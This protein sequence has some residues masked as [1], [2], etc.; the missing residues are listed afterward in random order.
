MTGLV[1][2]VTAYS[3][4]ITYK[5]MNVIPT[6]P[7][8]LQF[9]AY[10][11][12]NCNF[13]LYVSDDSIQCPDSSVYNATYTGK[14]ATLNLFYNGTKQYKFGVQMQDE[15][16][17]YTWM[18]FLINV[19]CPSWCN[20]KGALCSSDTGCTCNNQWYGPE[21]GCQVTGECDPFRTPYQACGFSSGLGLGNQTCDYVD[22]TQT[23][24]STCKLVMC[25]PDY[26]PDFKNNECI[27]NGTTTT[28]GSHGKKDFLNLSKEEFI[29]VVVGIVVGVVI[30]AGGVTFYLQKRARGK[31]AP[32]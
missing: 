17:T 22:A 32:I 11:A 30:I 29:G 27:K 6:A 25:L 10:N 9:K 3:N 28:T 13:T 2:G 23:K 4:N 15:S 7:D 20:G 24:W 26:I 5:Y 12:N 31:Y 19:V 21:T 18:I 14:S 8:G 16:C 1:K